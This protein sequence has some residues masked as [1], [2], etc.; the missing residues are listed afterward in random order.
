MQDVRRGAWRRLV[1]RLN[2]INDWLLQVRLLAGQP[3]A[4]LGRGAHLLHLGLAGGERHV[5]FSGVVKGRLLPVVVGNQVVD[6]HAKTTCRLDFTNPPLG[7]KACL[8]L[9]LG[10]GLLLLHQPQVELRDVAFVG[11]IRQ[12]AVLLHDCV[13]LLSLQLLKSTC[14]SSLCLLEAVGLF[15]LGV[16]SGDV[17][18]GLL[19]GRNALRNAEASRQN[20]KRDRDGFTHGSSSQT[21][22]TS[23]LHVHSLDAPR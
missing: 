12:I 14:R 2:R 19:I 5:P 16:S 6:R 13:L 22:E 9:L 15:G 8:P 10:R 11:A 3:A 7:C 21:P 20:T 4:T 17:F 18:L 23:D 1:D